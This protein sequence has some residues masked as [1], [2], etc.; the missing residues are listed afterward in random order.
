MR[1]SNAAPNF[2]ANPPEAYQK[3]IALIQ[4]TRIGDL[5]QTYQ[6]AESLKKH[7]PSYRVVLICRESF[8]KPLSFLLDTVFDAVYFIPTKHYAEIAKTQRLEDVKTSFDQFVQ[9]VHASEHI[10]ALINLSFSKAGNYLASIIK[11]DFKIGPYYDSTNQMRINDKWSTFLYS[12]VLTGTFNPFCLVDL[13]KNII[14]VQTTKPIAEEAKSVSRAHFKQIVFHPFASLERKMW[15]PEKWVEIIYKTLKDNKE[16]KVI[17]VGNKQE[18]LRSKLIEENPL[19]KTFS[20]RI[21]NLTGK[22]SLEDVY[23]MLE[24]SALFVGHDSMVGH[25][26]AVTETPTLTISLGS[27]RPQETTPYHKNA[28][29]LAPKTKCFPCFPNEKCDFTQCHL[30]IPHQ[31]VT[32]SIQQLIKNGGISTQS[33]KDENSTFHL[34]SVHLYKSSMNAYEQ[35][36]IVDLAESF[37]DS[38]DIFRTITRICFSYS[39][40]KHDENLPFPRLTHSTHQDLLSTLQGVQH[41]YELCDFGMKY[42]RFILEEISGQAPSIVK[43]K[44]YSKKIDEVDQLQLLVKKT[45]P[46]LSPIIDYLAL[47]KANLFGENVV[48]LTESSFYA[49][50]DIRTMMQIFYELIENIIVEHKSTHPKINTREER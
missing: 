4:I 30:D 35:Q 44:D 8:G 1:N 48:Q 33:L 42:S 19:L 34:G 26:A 23:K 17:I 45:H 40:S 24:T 11:S 13:F 22:T 5:I 7:H 31:L 10:S 15:R 37:P 32:N 16:F 2:S 28:Y 29:T 21:V 3:T 9:R 46:I 47:R 12:H 14:G 43:I 50:E 18:V 25:M 41:F 6:A 39:L 49:Y 27:V 38:K 36:V 20:D